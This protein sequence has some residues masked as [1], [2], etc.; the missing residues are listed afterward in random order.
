MEDVT[1]FKE[2]IRECLI[3]WIGDKSSSHLLFL[4]PQPKWKK[5]DNIWSVAFLV[6]HNQLHSIVDKWTF[7]FHI[8]RCNQI[9]KHLR[10][11]N[12]TLYYQW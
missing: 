4:W 1:I 9:N 2:L 12:F 3:I 10:E 5:N 7:S 11:K 8:C 6:G